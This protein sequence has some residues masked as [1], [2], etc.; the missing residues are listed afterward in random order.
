MGVLLRQ[1]QKYPVRIYV[2]YRRAG[3]LPKRAMNTTND[4]SRIAK[5]I[6]FNA[7]IIATKLI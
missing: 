3:K 7:F 1:C 2:T 5:A 6:F 4:R